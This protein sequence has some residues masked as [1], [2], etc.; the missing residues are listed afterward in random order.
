MTE[1]FSSVAPAYWAKGLPVIPLKVMSKRPFFDHWQQW[2]ER[3]PTDSEQEDWLRNYRNNNIGLPLGKQSNVVIIDVDTENPEAIDAI[4]SV[5]PKSPWVRT[6]SKGFALAYRFSGKGGFKIT[7]KGV[8]MVVEMLSTGNQIVLP[9][10]IHP[11]T[12]KPYTENQPLHELADVLVPLPDDIEE[13]LRAALSGCIEFPSKEG[14][15]RLTRFAASGERDVTMTKQAGF[16]A[17]AIQ[18]GD[19]SVKRAL[20]AMTV[21][22]Q[23][24]TTQ[25]KGDPV[26]TAKGHRQIIQFLMSDLNRRK[27]ILPPGWDEDLTP[28][29]K[30]SLGLDVDESQ[31]EWTCP[32]LT[33]YIY[34]KLENSTSD[35]DPKR[36]EV[37]DFIL[38]KVARSNNLNEVEKA[39][40]LKTLRTYTG[41]DVSIA[42]YHKQIKKLQEGPIAGINHTEI[43]TEVLRVYEERNGLLTYFQEEFYQWTGAYWK[44]IHPRELT[45][46][47]A[48]EFGDLDAAKKAQDHKGIVETIRNVVDKTYIRAT[49]LEGINFANG[50]LTKELKLVPH[51]PE[52][53]MTYAL[54]YCYRPELAGKCPLF[55]HFLQSSWGDDEDYESKRQMVREAMAATIFGVTTMF[56]Q[57]FLLKGVGQSGKSVLLNIVDKM[58]PDSAKCASP[59]N[60]WDGEYT[61]A[62]FSTALLN[63]AGELDEHARINGAVFKKMVTG[64]AFTGRHIYGAPFNFHPKC[65]HWFASNYL[66]KSRDTSH[67][68]NRRWMILEFTKIVP[69]EKRVADLADLIISEEIEAI[70][71]WAAESLPELL[72]RGSYTTCASAEKM[73]NAMALAN[74]IV[75]QWFNEK[76]IEVPNG[77]LAQKDIY[78]NFFGY[79]MVNLGTKV[80]PQ[81]NF[82]TEFKQLLMEKQIYNVKQGPEG[83][84]Y[85]NL[86]LK[87]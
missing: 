17:L 75:R 20:D 35:A 77:T 1:L 36:M 14:K 3:L 24:Y 72:R 12:E 41:T 8:G 26:D 76:V 50:F 46:V 82:Y 38:K 22:C 48:K 80:M 70:V 62:Q 47:V 65:A 19:M 33:D 30:Q 57:A 25:T 39:K 83:E 71:A 21:W 66:P 58:V 67:G 78:N 54:D 52:Q 37:V 84:I 5:L 59:P 40:V 29:E 42:T 79:N 87:K 4:M 28:E 34:N 74:S 81:P 85:L 69:P 86:G 64:D 2:S 63:I 68:F 9:P 23:T 27:A 7:G 13:Q 32:Q 55:F 45:E 60:E 43:A 11:D 16:F 6:G 51:Q 18:R 15:M 73:V 61:T 49:A 44:K 56:Q 10:S 53:G 31:E